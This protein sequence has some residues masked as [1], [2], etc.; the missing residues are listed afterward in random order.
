MKYFA[1]IVL[2]FAVLLFGGANAL[3]K[4]SK[5]AALEA[6]RGITTKKPHSSEEEAPCDI[7]HFKKPT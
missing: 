1:F 7:N 3:K 2:I 6:K 5:E 4:C